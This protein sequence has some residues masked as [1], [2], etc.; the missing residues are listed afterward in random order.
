MGYTHYYQTYNR[1]KVYLSDNE[2]ERFMPFLKNIID[3][4]ENILTGDELGEQRIPVILNSR[5]I[6]L[7]GIGDDSHELF[8]FP[9]RQLPYKFTYCKTARKPYDAPVCEI[10]IVLKHFLP[11]LDVWSDGFTNSD[12]PVEDRDVD[13]EWLEAAIQVKTRYGTET[14]LFAWNKAVCLVN[15][16]VEPLRRNL[17]RTK[18]TNVDAVPTGLVTTTAGRSRFLPGL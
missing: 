2:R 8:W 18:T 7:N 15:G 4:Y 14:K 13:E 9:L 12:P 17:I 1:K 6:V 3:R 11:D 16:K 5:E 10:L